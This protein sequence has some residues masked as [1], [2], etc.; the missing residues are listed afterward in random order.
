MC[1]SLLLDKLEKKKGAKKKV[2]IDKNDNVELVSSKTLVHQAHHGLDS[3]GMKTGCSA[4][5]RNKS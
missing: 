3:Q 1:T 4:N 2:P 5:R